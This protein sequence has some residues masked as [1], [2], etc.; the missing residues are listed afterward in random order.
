MQVE[1]DYLGKRKVGIDS[2][3]YTM[4]NAYNIAFKGYTN[5]FPERRSCFVCERI[6]D[7][8]IKGSLIS[9]LVGFSEKS[10]KKF[11]TEHQAS[12]WL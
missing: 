6:R 10:A 3:I 9:L 12:T 4:G 1:D 8:F 5:G 11:Q 7:S 2:A